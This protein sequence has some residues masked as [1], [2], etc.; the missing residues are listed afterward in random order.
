LKWTIPLWLFGTLTVAQA[1][2]LIRLAAEKWPR[3]LAANLVVFAWAGVA[4]TQAFC[5]LLVGLQLGTPLAGVMSVLGFGVMGWIFLA[6][7]IAVGAAHSLFSPRVVRATAWLGLMVLL[8]S[9]L[10]LGGRLIGLH[11]LYMFPAPLGLLLPQSNFVKFY[12]TAAVFVSEETLGEK[13][14]RLILFFPWAT[15]LSLGGLGIVFIS[16][17]ERHFWWRVIGLAG[18]LVAVVFS[19][20]RIGIATLLVVGAGL[21]FLRAGLLGRLAVIGAGLLTLFTLPLFGIDPFLNISALRKSV[22]SARAGSSMARDLIYRKSWEGFLNSPWIGHGWIGESVH[23]KEVLPIGSHSTIYGLLYTG[24]LP[25]FLAFA[26]AMLSMFGVLLFRLAQATDVDDRR[27]IQVGLA[28]ILCFAAFC[29]FEQL[30][31]LTLSCMF[32]LTWIGACVGH[33][34]QGARVAP[35]AETLAPARA[36]KPARFSPSHNEAV[37]RVFGEPVGKETALRRGPQR[38]YDNA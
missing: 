38:R 37:D 13:M 14:T 6:L 33:G 4:L 11:S 10:A 7:A 29:P 15:A 12:A 17:L 25:T 5:S 20:S 24:G 9:M 21:A 18:G 23:P 36:D 8:L 19:W 30:F 32:M 28:L 26:M 34:D 22:D 3:G 27:N 2:L 35:V 31:S 16:T 1:W